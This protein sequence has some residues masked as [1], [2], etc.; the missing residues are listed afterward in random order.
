MMKKY[1]MFPLVCLLVLGVLLLTACNGD[2]G[3]ETQTEQA[4]EAHQ[5]TPVTDPGKEATCTESGLTEGSHC[6]EC[7]EVL[8]AQTVIPAKGHTPGAAADCTHDQTCTVCQVVLEAKLGH[9]YRATVTPPTCTEQGYTTHTCTRCGDSYTDSYVHAEGHLLLT[10]P[11]KEATCTESGLTE[12]SHC[13]FCGEILVAQ[14]V[15]PAKGH[16]PGAAADC[17]H[18]QTC[19]VCGAVLQEKLG[20]SYTATVTAPTCTEQGYTTHTCTLCG[21]S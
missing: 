4:T 16:T 19:T 8:V 20:H 6:A 14:T 15:I 18:D 21:D 1:L 5:H 10:D 9:D 7:G 17:T 12:G 11:A 13:V 3:T 2:K